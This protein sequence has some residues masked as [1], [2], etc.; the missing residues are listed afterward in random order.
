ML[1]FLPFSLR[2]HSSALQGQNRR[3]RFPPTE[4]LYVPGINGG[5]KGGGWRWGLP[6]VQF[7]MDS[8]LNN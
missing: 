6:M 5:H 3:H 4:L 8:A 1:L 7:F 2:L